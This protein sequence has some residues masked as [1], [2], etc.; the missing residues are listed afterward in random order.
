M[1]AALPRRWFDL[2]VIP[3]HDQVPAADNVVVSDGPLNPMRPALH[4]D[5]ERGLILLGGPSAHY[6]WDNDRMLAAVHEVMAT[7]SAIQWTV[8]SSRRTPQPLSAS[9]AQDP[10]TGPCFMPVERTAPEWLPATLAGC[11]HAWVSVD[12]A[13]MIYEALSAGARVGLLPLAVRRAGRVTRIAD[14]LAARGMVAAT[15]QDEAPHSPAPLAEAD[16]V[17]ALILSRWPTPDAA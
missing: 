10:V 8:C 6:A 17:A 12:S 1:R 14:D 2:C 15:P 16:R 4:K 5:A 13:A 11:G 7:R 3:R 9:L